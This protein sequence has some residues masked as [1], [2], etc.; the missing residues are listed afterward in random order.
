MGYVRIFN[1]LAGISNVTLLVP[2]MVQPYAVE[3][4]S[5]NPYAVQ[6]ARY[7]VDVVHFIS[8]FVDF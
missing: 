5:Y 6:Q 2:P 3:P 8:V 7:C 4:L 1:G